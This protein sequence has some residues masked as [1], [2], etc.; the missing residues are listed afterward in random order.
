MSIF[1]GLIAAMGSM[2]SKGC[3]VY[4]GLQKRLEFKN[5]RKP[6]PVGSLLVSMPTTV[7]SF[8]TLPQV[9]DCICEI[10]SWQSVYKINT[11][12]TS[13][14]ENTSFENGEKDVSLQNLEPK[15]H[16]NS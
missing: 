9:K 3:K 8:G 6:P 10:A 4:K 7:A 5:V 16:I 11:T 14:S 15:S 2:R 12:S 1:L 13:L